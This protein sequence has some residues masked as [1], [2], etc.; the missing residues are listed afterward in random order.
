M[1]HHRIYA[2]PNYFDCIGEGEVIGEAETEAEA[3][4]IVSD[5]FPQFAVCHTDFYDA[6]DAPNV[7]GIEADGTG[8]YG[9]H[10]AVD[11]NA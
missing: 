8:A 10:Y 7:Y 2:V 5:K 11:R 3:I 6:E 9:I 1:T 4:K